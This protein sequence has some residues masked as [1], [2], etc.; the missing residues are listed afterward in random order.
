M[1]KIRQGFLTQEE[2][3]KLIISELGGTFYYK[4]DLFVRI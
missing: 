4:G 1:V 2:L 3:R